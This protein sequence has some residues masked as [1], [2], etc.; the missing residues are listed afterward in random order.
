[1]Q[2]TEDTLDKEEQA[3]VEVICP[4][5]SATGGWVRPCAIN[6]SASQKFFVAMGIFRAFA[7]QPTATVA[8]N[9]T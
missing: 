7:E 9:D 8:E 6:N 1:M 3:D 5:V 4:V 2:P